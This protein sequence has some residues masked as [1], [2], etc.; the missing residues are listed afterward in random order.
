MLRAVNAVVG[1]CGRRLEE[2][3][4]CATAFDSSEEPNG[5]QIRKG[6]EVLSTGN[7]PLNLVGLLLSP[8][9]GPM[10]M[11]LSLWS[12]TTSPRAY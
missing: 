2:Y 4:S 9:V 3:W 6:P 5:D 8:C 12:Q 11:D 1:I 7:R 10:T